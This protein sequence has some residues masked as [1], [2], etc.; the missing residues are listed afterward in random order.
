MPKRLAALFAATML[1]YSCS[2]SPAAPTSVPGGNALTSPPPPSN[3]G[4]AVLVGAGDIAICGSQGSELTAR[5]LD[6]LGGVV[7]ALGDN[8]YPNGSAAD[9]ANC[10]APTWGRHRDRTRP[11][12]GNHEYENPGAAA[13]FGYF[14]A[15][16]G[17]TGTGYYSYEV[18]AWHVVVLNSEV[19]A[20]A[21]S[22]QDQWLRTDLAASGARCTAAYWHRPRFSSG[23]HGDN[24]AMRDAWRTLYEF[25]AEVVIGAHDHLYERFGPQDADGRPDPARGIREFVVGTGGST[26]YAP[27][28]GHPN[29]EVVGGEWGVLSLTLESQGYRWEFVPVEGARFRDAGAG[30]CH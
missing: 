22:A 20:S 28:G 1:V 17:D 10:Y 18:G 13:Y 7:A 6:R 19:D 30:T 11:T 14:G 23:P 29:S 26:L 15:N 16:A 21:G 12:P 5:L 9:Y 27:K 8:A 25:G 2:G 4:P 3:F 24:P